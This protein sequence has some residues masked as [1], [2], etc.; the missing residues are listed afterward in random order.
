MDGQPLPVRKSTGKKFISLP[1]SL[2]I[3]D[4]TCLVL[5]RMTPRRQIEAIRDQFEQ[6]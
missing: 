3:I 6:L 5:K 1:Y 4:H 2:E